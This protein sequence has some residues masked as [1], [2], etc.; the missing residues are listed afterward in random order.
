ML[1]RLLKMDLRE[2]EERD[3]WIQF[4]NF[5]NPASF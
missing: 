1:R 3:V 2:E 4:S 5:T